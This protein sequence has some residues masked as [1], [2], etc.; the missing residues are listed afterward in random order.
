MSVNIPDWC[1]CL[2]LTTNLVPWHV[3]IYPSVHYLDKQFQDKTTTHPLCT[4]EC[5]HGF[6]CL[7][8]VRQQQDLTIYSLSAY[9]LGNQH[10]LV[11]NFCYTVEDRG[12][13]TV[14]LNAIYKEHLLCGSTVR[15]TV[16][17]PFPSMQRE[18]TQLY[19]QPYDKI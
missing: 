9:H 3:V 16:T 8:M 10:F 2:C 15:V 12:A 11:K 13:T 6:G 4:A 18:T 14:Q 7:C 5:V 19:S 17:R 1:F